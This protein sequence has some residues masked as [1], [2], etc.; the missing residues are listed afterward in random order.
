MNAE[1]LRKEIQTAVEMGL[2]I[3]ADKWGQPTYEPRRK[4]DH[5]PWLIVTEGGRRLRFRYRE[6]TIGD[7][8]PMIPEIEIEP[9]IED[10]SAEYIE[11]VPVP[12]AVYDAMLLVARHFVNELG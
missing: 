7:P 5:K 4:G 11:T 12:R 10:A 6:L 2:P 9:E 1:D 8:E 3:L